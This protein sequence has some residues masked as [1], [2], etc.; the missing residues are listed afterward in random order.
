MPKQYE[1]FHGE[2]HYVTEQQHLESQEA[3]KELARDA[4]H[5]DFPQKSLFGHS[6]DQRV[7]SCM[8]HACRGM[9][10]IEAQ[11]GSGS[12]VHE[13]DW[14][15]IG[16]A[17]FAIND[18]SNE[19]AAHGKRWNKHKHGGEHHHD[20]EEAFQP[21][22][23]YKTVMASSQPEDEGEEDEGEEA[24]QG[25]LNGAPTTSSKKRKPFEQTLRD[26]I[27]KHYFEGDANA[28][29]KIVAKSWSE[30]TDDEVCATIKSL[31]NN[32]QWEC[33]DYAYNGIEH[34]VKMANQIFD[35]VS[36]EIEHQHY[37]AWHQFKSHSEHI[38]HLAN[39]QMNDSNYV[40]A[41]DT[42]LMP[43]FTDDL[44]KKQPP[45]QTLQ[46]AANALM[47]SKRVQ[48][49]QHDRCH[50]GDNTPPKL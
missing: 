34:N 17:Q 2:K 26:L 38:R 29:A 19:R 25:K 11:H 20:E 36:S 5:Q 3:R 24:E 23:R 35:I 43:H 39:R 8:V 48:C 30:R 28:F 18:V 10:D 13:N 40:V 49:E 44:T 21:V 50:L 6:F 14:R 16:D 37:L 42:L 27:C 41:T 46:H 33:N 15:E 22:I 45:L 31:Q 7:L 32:M 1:Y 47:P 4:L 9:Y 12:R